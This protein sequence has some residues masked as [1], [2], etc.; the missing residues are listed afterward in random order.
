MIFAVSSEAW[1]AL[2]IAVAGFFTALAAAIP[3]IM[4]YMKAK[5]N[6]RNLVKS[7]AALDARV[8]VHDQELRVDTKPVAAEASALAEKKLD[9][10]KL[11]E[12][13]P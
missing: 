11:P 9:L 10:P 5:Q 6:E 2:V 7:D 1:T 13:I 3:G 12:G 4:A 8:S